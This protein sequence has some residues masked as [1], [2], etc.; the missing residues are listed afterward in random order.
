[1]YNYT[2]LKSTYYLAMAH[3]RVQ[4]YDRCCLRIFRWRRPRPDARQYRS[5][6]S[7]SFWGN[8][9][10]LLRGSLRWNSGA[11]AH[12]DCTG[13]CV[14]CSMIFRLVRRQGPFCFEPCVTVRA[15]VGMLHRNMFRLPVSL[16]GV[17][18]AECTAAFGALVQL[19]VRDKLEFFQPHL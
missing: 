4:G 15:H 13:W 3:H 17:H 10:T 19:F 1:M 7:L 8:R 9:G 11:L 18:W 14:S 5:D 2:I 6:G 16:H 12:F